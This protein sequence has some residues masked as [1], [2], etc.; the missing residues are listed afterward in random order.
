MALSVIKL[1]D[2]PSIW[3]SFQSHLINVLTLCS[4]NSHSS[5]FILQLHSYNSIKFIQFVLPKHFIDLTPNLDSPNSTKNYK[6]VTLTGSTVDSGKCL[7]GQHKLTLCL[8]Y[9]IPLI[10]ILHS[11]TP[12]SFINQ[13]IIF[14][15]FSN[16]KYS[17][18]KAKETCVCEKYWSFIP[19]NYLDL[20]YFKIN[21]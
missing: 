7:I 20:K 15:K 18:F 9:L 8:L 11:Y 4:S 14:Q 5:I 6:S 3:K 19:Q 16:H 12:D 10:T 17:A 21:T 1:L 13:I 2:K